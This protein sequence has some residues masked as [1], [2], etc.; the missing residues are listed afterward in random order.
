MALLFFL[1]LI[2][3]CKQLI[4]ISKWR[5]RIWM[6]KTKHHLWLTL[7]IMCNLSQKKKIV[8]IFHYISYTKTRQKSWQSGNCY[9]SLTKVLTRPCLQRA[10][11]LQKQTEKAV[12]THMWVYESGTKKCPGRLLIF[13]SNPSAWIWLI[14]TFNRCTT[15]R[16]LHRWS[17]AMLHVCVFVCQKFISPV[18]LVVFEIVHIFKGNV[19]EYTYSCCYLRVSSCS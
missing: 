15:G 2:K 7:E 19:R 10:T 16:G 9:I 8:Q 11:D 1:L 4:I 12:R 5:N 18:R 6:N 17:G 14:M 3:K 13:A